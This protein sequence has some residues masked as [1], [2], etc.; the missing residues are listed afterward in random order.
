M[1]RLQLSCGQFDRLALLP[2]SIEDFKP[3]DLG[4]APLTPWPLSERDFDLSKSFLA[5]PS[6]TKAYPLVG[7]PRPVLEVG[8]GEIGAGVVN[9]CMRC[10]RI[11]NSDVGAA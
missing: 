7:R 10:W 4:N 9:R 2:F 8:V 5:W 11:G 1:R 6:T 3:G